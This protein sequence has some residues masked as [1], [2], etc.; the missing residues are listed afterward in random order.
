MKGN[1]RTPMLLFDGSAQPEQLNRNPFD[2]RDLA[3]PN[4]PPVRLKWS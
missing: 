2:A 1:R 3:R 4:E